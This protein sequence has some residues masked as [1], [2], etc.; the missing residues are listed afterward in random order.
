MT[1]FRVTARREA[2]AV[3][4]ELGAQQVVVVD[5][6]V[7]DE[8]DVAVLVPHRVGDARVEVDDR[9]ARLH[10]AVARVLAGTG[11]VG[12]APPEALEQH[13]GT[14]IGRLAGHELESGDPAH[15]NQLGL[16]RAVQAAP[17]MRMAGACAGQ[18]GDRDGGKQ[19]VALRF[20]QRAADLLPQ[21]AFELD[22][23]LHELRAHR[24]AAVIWFI[25]PFSPGI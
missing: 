19:A 5:L 23:P 11:C 13:L 12:P 8:P 10:Q 24:R 3:A 7:E 2:V 20:V 9:Q 21:V 17:G 25:A 22:D 15:C 18:A 14:G 6:A 4:L 1:T 16:R